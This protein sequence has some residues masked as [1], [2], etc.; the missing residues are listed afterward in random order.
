MANI[1]PA[2]VARD[3]SGAA[4]VRRADDESADG[5]G[6]SS[7]R[8]PMLVA[9]AFGV[10]ALLLSAIGIYGVLAYGVSQRRTRDRHP[11]RARQL[12]P[13]TSSVSCSARAQD[14]GVGLASAWSAPT[15]S[16]A[17]WRASCSRRRARSD[18][19]HG[20]V[21]TPSWSARRDGDPGEAGVAGES[22]R[23]VEDD[24][25]QRLTGCRFARSF[26]CC[27][28]IAA[29]SARSFFAS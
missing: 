5:R 15:S 28:T 21:V 10:V 29:T 13:A 27:S 4:G 12:A 25:D 11:P 1:R 8:V 2:D 18:G 14:L 16:A 23:G 6:A 19:A 24:R 3:R 17:R 9:M 26:F 7:R 20:V 22:G